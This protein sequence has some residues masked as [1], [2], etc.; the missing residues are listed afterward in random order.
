MHHRICDTAHREEV[1]DGA[2]DG[3]I[4]CTV[5]STVGD[6][7]LVM[8]NHRGVLTE[9]VVIE[10]GG[11]EL[12]SLIR[13]TDV[14]SGSVKV[15]LMTVFV[16]EAE[17]GPLTAKRESTATLGD[18]REALAHRMGYRSDDLRFMRDGQV[19]TDLNA[20]IASFGRLSVIF[21]SSVVCRFRGPQYSFPVDCGVVMGQLKRT[22][23]EVIK[24]VIQPERLD[25][26]FQ[27]W[28]VES[29][30][31]LKGLDSGE[32]KARSSE[33]P[34]GQISESAIISFLGNMP[35]SN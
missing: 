18:A 29:S 16:F 8:A 28:I 25:L 3:E 10:S 32:E 24:S 21:R 35:E 19:L 26:L 1:V 12:Q 7:A 13:L 22:V 11:H 4:E 6:L 14:A 30:M 23:S 17:L 5:N 9:D 34:L 33:T 2:D 15:S 20:P 31:M 27:R